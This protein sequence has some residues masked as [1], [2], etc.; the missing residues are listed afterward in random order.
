[1]PD[2]LTIHVAPGGFRAAY[3]SGE[4]WIQRRDRLAVETRAIYLRLGLSHDDADLFTRDRVM[5]D[6]FDDLVLAARLS[7]KR[8]KFIARDVG[9]RRVFGMLAILCR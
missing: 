2:E 9:L 5:G 7:A 1:M 8:A 6:A 3:P 4:S